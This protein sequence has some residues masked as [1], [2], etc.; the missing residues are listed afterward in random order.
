M[1][2]KD[3]DRK[4][5]GMEQDY[6]VVNDTLF[7]YQVEDYD[8]KKS[9]RMSKNVILDLDQNDEPVAFEILHASK[10]FKLQNKHPLTQLIK[11]ELDIDIDEKSIVMEGKFTLRIRHKKEPKLVKAVT[12]NL[13]NLPSQDMHLATA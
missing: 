12:D 2:V 10:Y 6:D 7:F 4:E 9:I 1:K 11:I 5:L 3:S 13:L 8:Y